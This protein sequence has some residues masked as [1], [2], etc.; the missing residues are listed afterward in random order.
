MDDLRPI[1]PTDE[2]P[3]L[4]AFCGGGLRGEL[5][6]VENNYSQK[7]SMLGKKRESKDNQ[8]LV[9]GGIKNKG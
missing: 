3:S 8:Y 7:I 1:V 6:E 9:R 4:L 2:E 5:T